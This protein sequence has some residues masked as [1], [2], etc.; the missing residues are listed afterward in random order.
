MPAPHRELGAASPAERVQ[1]ERPSNKK[2]SALLAVQSS[3]IDVL[4]ESQDAFT[5]PPEC[6]GGTGNAGSPRPAPHLQSPRLRPSRPLPPE[7]QIWHEALP[8]RPAGVPLA[9]GC[10]AAAQTCNRRGGDFHQH[11]AHGTWDMAEHSLFNTHALKTGA[12]DSHQHRAHGTRQGTA[13]ACSNPMHRLPVGIALGWQG[14]KQLT[15]GQ[16]SV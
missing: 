10:L 7:Q 11:R 5:W 6:S 3:S 9:A 8:G 14:T 13:A 16:V 12:G 4:P 2:R 15:P 1:R